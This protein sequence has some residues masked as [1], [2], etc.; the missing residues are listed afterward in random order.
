MVGI[1]SDAAYMDILDGIK[2]KTLVH[3]ERT[4][5]A[6]FRLAAGSVLPSHAHPF[7]QTGYLVSGRL[8]LSID[9]TT[10][11]AGPGDSWCIPENG[12][13][14]ATVMEDSVALEIFSPAREDYRKYLDRSSIA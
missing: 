12:V 2:I 9:G 5:M 11:L 6:E 3:G 1:H 10:Y 7:E 4:L 14:G 13:H 8:K